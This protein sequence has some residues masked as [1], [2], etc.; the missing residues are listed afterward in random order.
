MAIWIIREKVRSSISTFPISLQFLAWVDGVTPWLGTK[1]RVEEVQ[2]DMHQREEES[3][4]AGRPVRK[5]S[6]YAAEVIIKG[7]ELRAMLATFPEPLK[8]N[9]QITASSQRSNYRNHVNLPITAST[10]TWYDLEDFVELDWLSSSPPVLHLLPLATSPHFTY[11]KRNTSLPGLSPHTSKFGSE[12]SH[13]CLLG[14]EQCEL[15]R[16]SVLPIINILV[17]VPQTQIS[18]ASARVTELKQSLQNETTPRG[19]KGLT[20]SAPCKVILDSC[21]NQLKPSGRSSVKKMLALLEEYI[22][23]LKET[24]AGLGDPQMPGQ[25][26]HHMPT[27]IVSPDEW[28]EFDN[29]YQIHC[30]NVFMDSAVR[31]VRSL[32][33]SLPQP[34]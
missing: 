10:S 27:A 19:K 24:E 32:S 4:V 28:A 2:A 12:H 6:F 16:M 22:A 33:S 17:A 3:M 23:A 18:L 15:Y 5:K 21:L 8:Q 9:V 26:N 34:A 29:V 25:Q 14:K 31:D 13:I 20:V 1:G 7:I 11:F 30:P